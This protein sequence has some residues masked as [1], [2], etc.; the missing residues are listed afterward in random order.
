MKSLSE[1]QQRI[2][3]LLLVQSV[4]TRS[5]T[6]TQESKET[7]LL[8]VREGA[9]PNVI[10]VGDPTSGSGILLPTLN[11]CVHLLRIFLSSPCPN[12]NLNL[13]FIL[14]ASTGSH[15]LTFLHLHFNCICFVLQ[16][17]AWLPSSVLLSG[18]ECLSGRAVCG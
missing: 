12:F 8:E 15:P 17:V 2:S 1:T 7:S 9:V 14:L 13:K 18:R 3:S 11:G 10:A 16:V 4:N 6:G 5:L